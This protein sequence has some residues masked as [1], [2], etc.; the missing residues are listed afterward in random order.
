MNK[1]IFP[2]AAPV[3]PVPM[4]SPFRK[5]EDAP[6]PAT[7]RAPKKTAPEVKETADEVTPQEPVTDPES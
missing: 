6:A 7:K 5:S 4:K 1:P 3:D 2:K